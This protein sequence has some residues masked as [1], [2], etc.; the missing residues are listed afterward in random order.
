MVTADALRCVLVGSL[1]L[2]YAFGVL[3]VWQLAGIAA[4]AGVG[5]V[6]GGLASTS[7]LPDV[8]PPDDLTGANARLELSNSAAMLAGPGLAGVAVGAIGAPAALV[9]DGI[10]FAASATIVATAPQ[11]HERATRDTRRRFQTEL[12][13]G[14]RTL[15][16]HRAMRATAVA[17]SVSNSGSR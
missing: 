14:V 17:A 2:A 1:P 15:A 13:E 5:T 10:S 16:A 12:W 9:A 6:V 3:T 8:V 4:L 7:Y 11:V